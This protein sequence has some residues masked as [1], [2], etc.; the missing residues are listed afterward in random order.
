MVVAERGSDGG[1]VEVVG[2]VSSA[3]PTAVSP[4][5]SKVCPRCGV[6]FTG[7]PGF[8]RH[9]DLCTG[10]AATHLSEPQSE[11]DSPV[12]LTRKSWY[13]DSEATNPAS[14]V[15][16]DND[17]VHASGG[18]SGGGGEIGFAPSI[19][20]VVVTADGTAVFTGSVDGTV[21]RYTTVDPVGAV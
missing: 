7:R 21:H 11:S 10:R 16:G 19:W 17:G 2:D 8:A 14:A 9:R 12:H 5:V 20:S 1:T 6:D 3:I 4:D 15:D 18:S 13:G